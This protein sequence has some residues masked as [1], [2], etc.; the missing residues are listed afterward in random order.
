M[1][2]RSRKNMWATSSPF[3]RKLKRE[4]KQHSPSSRRVVFLLLLSPGCCLFTVAAEDRGE[5]QTLPRAL[6]VD[7]VDELPHRKRGAVLADRLR[8]RDRGRRGG[9]QT[10]LLLRR[11]LRLNWKCIFFLQ[12]T[13]KVG[14]VGVLLVLSMGI[15]ISFLC[16]LLAL[17]SKFLNLLNRVG[18]WVGNGHWW[19][20]EVGGERERATT[21]GRCVP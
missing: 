21:A 6:E 9:R 1:R 16:A 19:E 2:E 11:L 8:G 5:P 20:K 4:Q 18:A 7:P 3:L 10:L 13:R 15:R 14:G 17:T 12:Q